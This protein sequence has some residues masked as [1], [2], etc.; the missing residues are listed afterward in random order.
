MM[1][2]W[3]IRENT[4]VWPGLLAATESGLQLMFIREL[5]IKDLWRRGD[6]KK[7]VSYLHSRRS[8]NSISF[9]EQ[10][11]TKEIELFEYVD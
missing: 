2:L 6:L 3:F 8:T 1:T 7:W 10:G 4:M 11:E 9:M 5:L